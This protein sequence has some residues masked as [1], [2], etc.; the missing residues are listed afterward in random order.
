MNIQVKRTI[1][2]QPAPS[3]AGKD[4]T[5]SISHGE[6]RYVKI[7]PVLGTVAQIRNFK[8]NETDIDETGNRQSLD[9]G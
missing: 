9:Y 6:Q 4:I 3:T 1:M 8:V 7:D 5:S 2:Q